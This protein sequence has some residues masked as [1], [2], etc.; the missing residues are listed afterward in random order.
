MPSLLLWSTFLH[1]CIISHPC[2]PYYQ[3]NC[4]VMFVLIGYSTIMVNFSFIIL[5]P[6]FWCFHLLSHYCRF[7]TCYYCVSP[8]W[9]LIGIW[10]RCCQSLGL[11]CL[12]VFGL[13][14]FL[15]YITFTSS[16]YVRRLQIKLIFL[17]LQK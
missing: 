14:I 7:W 17:G 16:L 2:G 5:S 11:K 15:T 8:S 13:T 6:S 1:A 12:F 4:S 9:K 10:K 3:F